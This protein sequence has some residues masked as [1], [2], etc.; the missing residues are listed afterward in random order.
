MENK[1]NSLD[2]EAKEVEKL[3]YST[4]DYFMIPESDEKR[5]KLDAPRPDKKTPSQMFFEYFIGFIDKV[6][7]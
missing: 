3:Y 7:E 2:H 4:C 5:M 6:E 1:V